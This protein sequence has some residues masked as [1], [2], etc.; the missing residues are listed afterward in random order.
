MSSGAVRSDGVPT[1]RME[2]G[3]GRSIQGFVNE[4]Y[5]PVVDKFLANF[6]ERSDLGAACAV[7]GTGRQVVDLWGGLAD[8]RTQRPW[9]A[10]TAAEQ[11]DRFIQTHVSTASK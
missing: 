3:D 2:L 6:V 9:E 8:S 4:G 5:G 10:E 11:V 1:V 7:Y